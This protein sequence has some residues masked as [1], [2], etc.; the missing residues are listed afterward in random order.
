MELICRCELRY[1]GG[2]KIEPNLV[3]RGGAR[4]TILFGP[5]GGGKT[6]VLRLLAGLARPDRGV[7]RA[8]DVVW[9]ETAARKFLKPQSRNVGMVFQDYAL[10]PHMTVRQ[11][12]SYGLP[13]RDVS[14]SDAIG[15]WIDVLGLTGLESR[16]PSELSGGQRQRVALARALVRKPVWMLLDE[17][18]AA[19]DGMLR[20]QVR[21]ELVT[22]L[23]LA[24]IPSVIVTHDRSE[25][26]SLADDIALIA[27]GRVV[28]HGSR[29]EVL[30]SPSSHEA[31]RILQFEN[32]LNA[33][34]PSATAIAAALDLDPT[35][36][37][38]RASSLRLISPASDVASDEMGIQE[39]I[40]A[41]EPE[42]DL[43]RV[44]LG[45]ESHPLQALVSRQHF[46]PRFRPGQSVK[47]AI[48]RNAIVRL[49]A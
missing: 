1:P 39:T 18:L 6:S 44:V 26:D 40:T 37:A 20:R 27:D 21:T 13:R 35:E 49:G 45:M 16:K 2:P 30:N 7:I 3:L 5:S 25:L 8:G 41:I 38:I 23:S 10:F 12:I 34:H 32:L 42:G 11:N 46:D 29:D 19:L 14:G 9:C 24:K 48:R 4:R 36:L 15:H 47:V 28:Q 33:D 43:L 17:P 22:A 31:A